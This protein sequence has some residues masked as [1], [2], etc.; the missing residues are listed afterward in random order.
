LGEAVRSGSFTWGEVPRRELVCLLGRGKGVAIGRHN[1][2]NPYRQMSI[3]GYPFQDDC[4]TRERGKVQKRS[5]TTNREEAKA[6]TDLEGEPQNILPRSDRTNQTGGR[7]SP[8]L[9]GPVG[10]NRHGVPTHLARTLNLTNSE[11]AED[12]LDPLL[13]TKGRS[14]LSWEGEAL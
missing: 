5:P 6:I 11:V 9:L 12:D 1:F 8:S 10:A 14:R 4:S 2:G 3:T 13:T 7:S